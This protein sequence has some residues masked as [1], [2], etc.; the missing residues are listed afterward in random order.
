MEKELKYKNNDI[1]IVWN[2]DNCIHSTLCWKGENGLL[3]V[4][5]PSKRPWINPNGAATDK[6]IER[7]NQCPSGALS[8]FKNNEET[9]VVETQTETIVEIKENGPLLVYGNL[10]LKDKEGNET[11]KNKVTALCRCGASEN[12]PFCDGTHIKI[13][14]K[15]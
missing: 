3:D 13:D 10:T 8:Y 1:T 2:P 14:F 4:F 15:G 6:I 9:E 11:K 5:N 7:I 12:K